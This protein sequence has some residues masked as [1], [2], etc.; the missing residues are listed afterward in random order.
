MRRL[1]T[2]AL[3]PLLGACGAAATT[4]SLGFEAPRGVDD[5]WPGPPASISSFVAETTS[6]RAGYSD[7]VVVVDG[8]GRAHRAA[9]SEAEG[10][11]V[12]VLPNREVR[13]PGAAP[14][15]DEYLSFEGLAMARGPAGA[16]HATWSA[17]GT[18]WY[19]RIDPGTYEGEVRTLV[20]DEAR[21]ANIAVRDDG[22]VL[23]VY[24]AGWYSRS[25]EWLL[26]AVRGSL[27]AGFE[28]STLTP[29]GCCEQSW[30]R[31]T[32]GLEVGDVRF[33]DD[34]SAHVVYGWRPGGPII[35][36]ISDRG[37]DWSLVHRIEAEVADMGAPGLLLESDGFS[38]LHVAPPGGLLRRLEVL[39][40]ALR[41]AY[42]HSATMIRALLAS[43]DPGGGRHLVLDAERDGQ[44]SIEYFG[45]DNGSQPLR[46]RAV[47]RSP[48]PLRLTPRAGGIAWAPDGRLL[49]PY[50]ETEPR[51]GYGRIGL[52]VGR[53]AE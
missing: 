22:E 4:D 38:I 9:I 19:A 50:L 46:L 43:T 30:G 5:H 27:E 8:S 17:R 52:A 40:E 11:P 21:R 10:W 48:Q 47:G 29:E 51:S 28:Q 39:G 1:I 44:R 15:P 33:L 2:L 37:G 34:G 35:D 32:W 45:L 25:P 26:G 16:L 6:E 41:P 18:L 3:M 23:I 12:F 31:G 36:Y 20:A 24:A 49:V 53:P 13:F 14:D 42:V 7:P